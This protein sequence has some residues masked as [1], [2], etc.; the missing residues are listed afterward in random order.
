[1]DFE[2]SERSKEILDLL[3]WNKKLV[4]KEKALIKKN[5]KEK[6]K[7]KKANNI[8]ASGKKMVRKVKGMCHRIVRGCKL[9]IG[10]VWGCM[11][12]NDVP[13]ATS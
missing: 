1:M 9:E 6:C 8:D 12:E 5:K 7:I 4:E 3:E 2:K 11:L 13:F 10:A